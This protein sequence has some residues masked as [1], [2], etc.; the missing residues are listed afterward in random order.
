MGGVEILQQPACAGEDA[1]GV[2]TDAAGVG[3]CQGYGGVGEG[4]E[5]GLCEWVEGHW[6][7]YVCDDGSGDN[8]G[9]GMCGEEDW[10]HVALSGEP[11]LVVNREK[12]AWD[13]FVEFSVKVAWFATDDVLVCK[14]CK[15]FPC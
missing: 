4:G 9:E 8:G 12:G 7:E 3:V 10:G 15:V 6:G 2:E 13:A 5:E 11:C 14:E 1:A